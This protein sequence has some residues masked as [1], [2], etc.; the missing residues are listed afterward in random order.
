M[1]QFIKTLRHPETW[2][3]SVQLLVLYVVS[4]ALFFILYGINRKTTE[5]LKPAVNEGKIAALFA[6][7]ALAAASNFIGVVSLVILA[8]KLKTIPPLALVGLPLLLI[9]EQYLRKMRS[10]AGEMRIHVAGALGLFV[11]M[12]SSAWLLMRHSPIK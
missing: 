12:V 1:E 2:T 5:P 11:G 6:V 9:L 10:G 3:I 4:T 8:K 7:F